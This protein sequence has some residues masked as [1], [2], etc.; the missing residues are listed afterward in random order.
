VSGNLHPAT[1]T[2]LEKVAVDN[3]FDREMPPEGAWLAFASTQAPLLLWLTVFSDSRLGMAISMENV[4]GGLAELADPAFIGL[5]LGAVAGRTV[6]TLPELHVL[7]RRAFQLSRT[8]PDALLATFRA[9]TANLPRATEAERLV[10]QRVGQDIFR[11]GLLE[12]WQGCCAVTGLAIPELLRGSHIKPWTACER[13]SER[14][15]VFNGLL[16]APNID[17]LFDAGFI[18]FSDTGEGLVSGSLSAED[19]RSLGIDGPL[20]VKGLASSHG[21]YLAFHRTM[22]FRDAIVRDT[23]PNETR[24]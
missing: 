22:V 9:T 20:S 3:G 10:V 13:D 12:Y 1:V 23:P 5:P 19:R 6:R 24:R 8:L 4:D 2:R 7:V 16:L 14:L 17:A 15:D 21:A 11:N 18:T